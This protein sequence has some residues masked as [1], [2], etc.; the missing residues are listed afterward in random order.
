MKEVRMECLRTPYVVSP[1]PL[2]SM[3]RTHW[4]LR[5]RECFTLGNFIT[6]ATVH[7]SHERPSGHCPTVYRSVRPSTIIRVT[8]LHRWGRGRPAADSESKWR[9]QL[10]GGRR[11]P[12]PGRRPHWPFAPSGGERP[13]SGTNPIGR[14]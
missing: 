13:R 3:A 1:N 6:D 5:G 2:A 7:P 8:N 10:R 9:L 14:P 12:R 4:R 11:T